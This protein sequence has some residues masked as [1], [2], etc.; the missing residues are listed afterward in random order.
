MTEMCGSI[1]EAF[2]NVHFPT[3]SFRQYGFNSQPC[4]PLL[5]HLLCVD[6][7]V[8]DDCDS[9]QHIVDTDD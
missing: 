8:E 7:K 9:C 5:I 3:L 6:V 2:M 1:L 4:L